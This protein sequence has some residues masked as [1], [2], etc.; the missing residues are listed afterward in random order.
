MANFE[1]T[2]TIEGQG[3]TVKDAW[4]DAVVSFS[5]NW[6]LERDRLPKNYKRLEDEV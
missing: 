6:E 3:E 4:E 1:F 2:I 5:E